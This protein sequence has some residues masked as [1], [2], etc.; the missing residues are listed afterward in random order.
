MFSKV[1]TPLRPHKEKKDHMGCYSAPHDLNK[2]KRKHT[3]FDEGG[4]ATPQKAKH[5]GGWLVD[6]PEDFSPRKGKKNSWKSTATPSS[7]SH[8]ISSLTACGHASS[9]RSSKKLWKVSGGTP[10]SHGSSKSVQHR[11]SASRFSNSGADAI[12]RNNDRW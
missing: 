3:Q 6:D 2:Y 5:R 8:R 12:R 9:S 11:Y 10:I 1:S 7:K 4:F